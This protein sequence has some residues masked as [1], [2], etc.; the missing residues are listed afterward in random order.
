MQ[1]INHDK[2]DGSI[3]LEINFDALNES[4][5]ILTANFQK[6]I[7]N[8]N[9]FVYSNEGDYVPHFHVVS[10]STNFDCCIQINRAKYFKHGKHKDIFINNS[11]KKLLNEKLQEINKKTGNS[12]WLDIQELYYFANLNCKEPKVSIQPDYTKLED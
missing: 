4:S 3:M 2:F 7:G 8:C 5:P 12:Y 9:I 6:K 1:E 10:K 11:Q